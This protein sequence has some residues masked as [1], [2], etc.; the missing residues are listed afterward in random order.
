MAQAD[1][2]ECFQ[3]DIVLARYRHWRLSLSRRQGYLGWCLVILS[4]HETDAAN[5]TAAE[6]EELWVII[7][8]PRGALERLFRPDHYNY[9]FLGNVVRHVHLHL[10]PRYESPR[11]F[12]GQTFRDEHWGWFAI[13]ETEEAP[14]EILGAL[15][16]A[17]RGEIAQK[18]APR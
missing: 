18:G 11:Q 5:L 10:M 9:A 7:G 13:P 3:R 8:G 15:A 1:G 12:Q 6:R 2:C 16:E 17:V 14:A 4:R